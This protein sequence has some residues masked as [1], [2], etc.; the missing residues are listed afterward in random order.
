MP[1]KSQKSVT[2]KMNGIPVVL[3][4]KP[5]RNV[6]VARINLPANEHGS[7]GKDGNRI[8]RG[9]GEADL[10]QAKAEAHKIYAELTSK[11]ERG[12]RVS[13]KTFRSLLTEYL[14]YLDTKR[15]TGGITQAAYDGAETTLSRYYL[16]FFEDR[17][18]GAITH[19][20]LAQHTEW[21]MSYAKSINDEVITYE[22]AGKTITRPFK[23]SAPSVEYLRKERARFGKLMEY[24]WRQ[25]YLPHERIPKYE[26]IK[27]RGGKREAFTQDEMLA[28]QKVS[29]ER[30]LATTHKKH[31]RQRILAHYR[32]L[33]IYLT[34]CRPQEISNLTFADLENGVDK[35]GEPSWLISLKAHHLKNKEHLAHKRKITPQRG[36]GPLVRNVKS[37]Y[38]EFDNHDTQPSDFIFHN[39]DGSA[40]KKSNKTVKAVLAEAGLTGTAYSLY[41]FRHTF[42]TERLYERQDAY[43]VARWVGT[44]MPMVE[45]HYAHL[46]QELEHQDSPRKENTVILE[47]FSLE[48]FMGRAAAETE[49]RE[50]SIFE[51][52]KAVSGSRAE[53]YERL[54]EELAEKAMASY[55]DEEWPIEDIDYHDAEALAANATVDL[56]GVKISASDVADRIME[57]L[58]KKLEWR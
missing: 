37:L 6:W 57:R 20:D 45:A 10:E 40:V 44:S 11:V 41:S 53:E 32:M 9:T 35:A 49:I 29:A 2:H 31:K 16:P 15:A 36:L 50:P 51:K 47:P 43:F 24:A 7:H 22:R 46:K 21:R 13:K 28:I 55:D 39:E 12:E 30:I 23:P 38:Q 1:R 5:G 56:V 58:G 27:G 3:V 4:K 25:G 48:Y 14:A 42:I 54:C 18:I 17:D 19:R 52:A 8:D 33:F 26:P 34:G